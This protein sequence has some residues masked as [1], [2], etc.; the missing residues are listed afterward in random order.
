MTDGE[1]AGRLPEL[2]RIARPLIGYA[3]AEEDDLVQE[4]MI[5]L[6]LDTSPRHRMLNWLRYLRR[7]GTYNLGGQSEV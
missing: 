7:G 6:W 5:A 3:Q 2:R 4:G 1:L